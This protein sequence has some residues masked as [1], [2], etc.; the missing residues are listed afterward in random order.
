MVLDRIEAL[1]AALDEAEAERHR[2]RQA[3]SLGSLHTQADLDRA[4][5]KAHAE[6]YLSG[7]VNGS[8]GVEPPDFG[9]PAFEKAPGD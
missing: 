7:W 6:A 4:V 1:I 8:N 9:N 3:A 2:W 5:A